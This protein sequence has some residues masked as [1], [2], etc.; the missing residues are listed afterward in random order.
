MNKI[1][2]DDVIFQLV[3]LIILV[4]IAA[5]IVFAIRALSK[6]PKQM[7]RIEKKLDAVSKQNKKDN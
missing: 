4:V 3:F 5:L 6:R 2:W 1:M 7:D